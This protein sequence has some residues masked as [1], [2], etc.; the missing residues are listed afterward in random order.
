M[1]CLEL[2]E[3]VAK[4]MQQVQ[5]NA[6][7]VFSWGLRHRKKLAE[8]TTLQAMVSP[9]RLEMETFAR[10]LERRE[11]TIEVA[12]QKKLETET[13]EELTPL[14][15]LAEAMAQ[16]WRLRH[17]QQATEAICVRVDIDPI[18]AMEYLD[19]LGMFM[20]VLTLTFRFLK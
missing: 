5:W 19:E 10:S 14:I 6:P 1:N 3:A 9:A 8:L 18:A 13:N 12:I 7:I 15:E 2:A 17:P 16:F 20:C 11:Y 4:E